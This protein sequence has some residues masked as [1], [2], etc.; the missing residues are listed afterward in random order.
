MVRAAI[1]CRISQDRAGAGL[2]VTRQQDDCRA[3][4]E[5]RGWEVI[6]VYA[7]NDVSAYSG[8]VRPAWQRL[9]GDVQLSSRCHSL[10]IVAHSVLG[11]T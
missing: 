3:L 6:D 5:R 1:Y 10:E 8:K 9:I 7:D 2:G 11:M 4:C